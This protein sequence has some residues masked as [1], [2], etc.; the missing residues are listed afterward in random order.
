M[1]ETGNEIAP[2]GTQKRDRPRGRLY[3]QSNPDLTLEYRMR[4]CIS[5]KVMNAMANLTDEKKY[6]L[7]L[8]IFKPLDFYE[9]LFEKCHGQ[10]PHY[11]PPETER[12]PHSSR[13]DY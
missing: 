4:Q 3:G 6:S 10:T 5:E 1:N 2:T 12:S 13:E 11:Q 7:Y 9:L 8:D